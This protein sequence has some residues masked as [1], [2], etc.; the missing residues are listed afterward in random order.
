MSGGPILLHQAVLQ[1]VGILRLAETRGAFKGM[2]LE[3]RT[4]HATCPDDLLQGLQ[5]GQWQLGAIAME[6]AL[7]WNAERGAD[8]VVLGQLEQATN[9]QLVAWPSIPSIADLRGRKVAVDDLTCGFSPLLQRLLTIG[10]VSS[11]DVEWIEVGSSPLRFNALRQGR[12]VAT[13]LDPP[14]DQ[15][16]EQEGFRLLGSVRDLLPNY[17]GVALVAARK[18][19]AGNPGQ[20]LRYL[21]AL[22]NAIHWAA[23]PTNE[24]AV[25]KA[26]GVAGLPPAVAEATRAVM[27][28]DLSIRQESIDT[29]FELLTGPGTVG[30]PSADWIDLEY[31]TVATKGG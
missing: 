27:P 11:T 31:L 3:V 21:R 13:L 14:F 23:L 30:A 10:G 24:A 20:M 6:G 7:R 4:R 19:L 8:F 2:G 5:D 17:P 12:A 15:L 1:P 26:L 9:L 16:A 28:S 25:V 18:W 29:V 22:V